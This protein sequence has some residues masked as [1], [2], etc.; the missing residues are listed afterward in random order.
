MSKSMA[1][2]S[3]TPAHTLRNLKE[4]PHKRI[5]VVPMSPQDGIPSLPKRFAQVKADLVSSNETAVAESWS[6]LL[7]QLR[8]EVASIAEAKTPVI[9]TIDFQDLEAPAKR[10]AFLDDLKTRGAAVIRNVVRKAR[11]GL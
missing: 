9:P 3:S 11:P 4:A 7:K 2:K 6:R 10:D 1:V 8:Q 5:R